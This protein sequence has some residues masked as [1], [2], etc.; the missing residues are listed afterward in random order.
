[1]STCT[2]EMIRLGRTTIMT[3]KKDAYTVDT[4]RSN[5]FTLCM[6]KWE[7]A[8]KTYELQ[9]IKATIILTAITITLPISFG[10]LNSLGQQTGY[11]CAYWCFA[12]PI[13]VLLIAAIVIVL[14]SVF[15]KRNYSDGPGIKSLIDVHRSKNSIT[16]KTL[17]QILQSIDTTLSLTDTAI[18]SIAYSLRLAATLYGIA[19]ILTI[20]I[21]VA[22]GGISIG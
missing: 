14:L 12:V 10:T 17:D 16:N 18:A 7:I 9:M 22:A 20:A 3:C 21:A 2:L 11:E 15:C 13:G 8:E 1:M 5:A 4:Y 19:L 6:R